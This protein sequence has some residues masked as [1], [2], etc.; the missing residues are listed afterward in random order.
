MLTIL[1]AIIGIA[2]MS[3]ICDAA[4]KLPKRTHRRKRRS[5]GI[6]LFY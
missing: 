6:R 5:K 2:E 4:K 3:A 1:K